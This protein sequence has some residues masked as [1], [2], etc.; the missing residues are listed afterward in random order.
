[1]I[2]SPRG[3][4]P[5]GFLIFFYI[6]EIGALVGYP[7]TIAGRT[8]SSVERGRVRFRKNLENLVR[9]NVYGDQEAKTDFVFEAVI[10]NL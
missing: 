4:L 1:M 3:V 10:E 2:N 5:R 8:Q 9:A 7:A 6:A